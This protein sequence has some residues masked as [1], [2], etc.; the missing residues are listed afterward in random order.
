MNDF[1][2]QINADNG[3]WAETEILGDRAIVKVRASAATLNAIAATAT[4]RR[5]PNITALTASLSTLS[6]AQR[7]AIRNEITD[8]GYSVAELNAAIPNLNTATLGQV[9]NL[10]AT[11][12]RKPRY[13]A[14]T[15]AII[16][17]GETVS[18]R[19]VSEINTQVA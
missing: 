16:L 19:P 10:L 13:D 15:D 8:A 18:C 2:P 7:T 14:N 5:I 1:T 17:D 3:A 11:R 9:F 12:R 6:A 4:F